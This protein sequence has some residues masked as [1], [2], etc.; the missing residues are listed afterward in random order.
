MPKLSIIIPNWNGK[1]LLSDCLKSLDNQIFKDFEIIVVDN[2]S[3]DCSVEYL[4]NNYPKIRILTLDKNYGFSKAINQGIKVA[5][6][7]YLFLLN[8]DTEIDR[9][10]LNILNIALD[11]NPDIYFC[12]TKMIYFHDHKFINDAGDIF[13]IYGIAHQRGKGEQDKGQYDKRE[14]VFGACAGGAIYRR[15]FFNKVGLL[16][17]DFFAYLEDIDLSL[18]GQ[19]L[20]YKCLYVPEAIVYHLD[21]GTS[22]KINNMARFLT[23]RNSLFVFFKDFPLFLIIILLP[24]FAIGQIRNVFIGIKH[25][26][27]VLIIKVYIDF[28]KNIIKT[29]KKRKKIQSNKKVSNMYILSILSKKYPFSIIKSFKNMISI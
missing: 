25:R 26:C 24:F 17:E 19:L 9:N 1:D 15:N 4:K 23:L 10:C 28:F 6:G 13:S 18:R 20:G 16:D 22:K 27:F 2:G 8:N 3:S 5:K 21:G 12:A 7:E 29:L 11:E 14:L